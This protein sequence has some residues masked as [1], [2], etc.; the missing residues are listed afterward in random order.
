MSIEKQK[1]NEKIFL[2]AAGST[3][4][5]V[6][7][8]VEGDGGGGGR[9][10]GAVGRWQGG[11]RDGRAAVRGTARQAA[12]AHGKQNKNAPTPAGRRV[13]GL[14][15]AR[16]EKIHLRQRGETRLAG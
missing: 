7:G 3:A 8:S 9:E 14:S 5:S 11:E 10:G 4:G 13:Q 12:F 6:A 2:A 1:K 15:R 16:E